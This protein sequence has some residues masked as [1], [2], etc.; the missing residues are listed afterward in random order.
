MKKIV[1]GILILIFIILLF[2]IFQKQKTGYWQC[3][4]GKWIKNGNPP[5]QQ[6]KSSCPKKVILPN[7]K[8]GCLKQG[9]VWRKWG[10][11]PVESCNRKTTDAGRL[12]FDNS[13]CEGRCLV[14]LPKEKIQPFMLGKIKI[15]QKYGQCSDWVMNLGCLVMMEQ[16]K[17]KAI[18]VD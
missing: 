8:D 6:P 14:N 2:F 13:E 12:C 11:A 3:Q 9:G 15:N 16:G 7:N 1:F 18:C 5:Y 17:A 10:V 4:N